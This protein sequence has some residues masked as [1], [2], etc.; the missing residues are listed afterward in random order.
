MSL[1]QRSEMTRG[2]TFA[3][4]A[5]LGATILV[6]NRWFAAVDDEV[7]IIDRAAAPLSQT[8]HLFLE[9]IGQ[10]E[11][12]PLYDILLHG[13]LRLTGANSHLLRVPAILFYLLGIWIVARTAEMLGGKVTG[14]SALC[15]LI[16]SPYGFHFGRLAAWYSF[17]FMLVA[18]ETFLYFRYE[19]QQSVRNWALLCFCSLALVYSNY[20]G[21]A[22]L[23]LLAVDFLIGNRK[24]GFR[25]IV[26]LVGMGVLLFA[27]FLPIVFAFLREL[28]VGVRPYVGV[29]KT[30]LNAIYVLYAMFISESVAPWFWW[31]GLPATIAVAVLVILVAMHSPGV[32]KRLLLYFF[33]S[34]AAMS[35]IGVVETKRVLMILPWLVLPIALAVPSLRGI[36]VRRTFAGL[37]VL[38]V[39]IGWFG[40]FDRNLYSAPHWVEPW[41]GIAAQA[42]DAV[43]DGG[44]VI[45]NN[46]S[47][48]FYLTYLLESENLPAAQAFSGFLP[49]STRRSHVYSPE[50][51]LADG[52]STHHPMAPQVL[53]VK[54]L[55]FG[56]PD[57][58]TDQT[59]QWLGANCNLVQDRQLV[60]DPGAELKLRYGPAENQKPWRI[61]IRVYGCR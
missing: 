8:A 42:A 21:W 54:G 3:A 9:G 11:H 1:E 19:S 60:H 6:S 25:A 48:F 37:T 59:Q 24:A 36:T 45:G 44:I 46:S 35:I 31:L 49:Y 32:G 30:T 41:S 56:T 52:D 28:H 4:L 43:R 17:C 50:Q 34:F 55:H 47:F 2:R 53:L 57:T 26:P 13:W 39:A 20:F 14:L 58:A 15:F 22:L 61:E 12:P 29:E 40:I 18:L 51:W 10:H 33:A 5:G 23:G 16:V 38:I 7:S 27:A